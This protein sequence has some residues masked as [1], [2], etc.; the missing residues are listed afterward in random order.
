[1]T[2]GAEV[3]VCGPETPRSAVVVVVVTLPTVAAVVAVAAVTTAVVVVARLPTA[4]VAVLVRLLAVGPTVVVTVPTVVVAK[5]PAAFAAVVTVPTVDV[6]TAGTDL[7]AVETAPAAVLPADRVA[8][9]TAPVAF[10]A[11]EV[12]VETGAC[13][14]GALTGTEAAGTEDPAAG[15]LG[16]DGVERGVVGGLAPATP[17]GGGVVLG[18]GGVASAFPAAANATTPDPAMMSAR[19]FA[20][21]IRTSSGAFPDPRRI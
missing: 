4:L 17:T 14:T 1:V 2:A 21:E 7:V 20:A 18:R 12:T 11:V 10:A 16:A 9:A 13:A 19:N 6:A 5:L 3:G 15:T 8:P